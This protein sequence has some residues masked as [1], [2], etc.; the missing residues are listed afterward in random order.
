MK[1][2]RNCKTA[3]NQQKGHNYI[4]INN[5]FKC[6]WTKFSNQKTEWLNGFK[7]QNKTKP[8]DPSICCLQESSDGKRHR[9]KSEGMEK[10]IP[11]KWKPKEIWGSYT[12]TK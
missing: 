10:D 1:E 2:Q 6:K 9:P 4:T 11:S 7:K 5:Y 12:Q 8:Q 3:R